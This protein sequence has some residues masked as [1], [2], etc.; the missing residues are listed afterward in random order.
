[1]VKASPI[2][3]ASPFLAFICLGTF[4]LGFIGLLGSASHTILGI[5][6]ILYSCF[7]LVGFLWQRRTTAK[8]DQ[9]RQRAA[10][11]D[12][13]LLASEQIT[14]S[15]GAFSL[16]LAMKMRLHWTGVLII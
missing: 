7:L 15:E 14:P 6:F 12:Q 11:G 9:R 10:S 8:L 13:S 16:P 2:P 3:G 4:I 1:M 5:L